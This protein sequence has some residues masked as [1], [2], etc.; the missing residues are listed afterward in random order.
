M[1]DL[2]TR[3]ET[4]A[5]GEAQ[6]ARTAAAEFVARYGRSP[7]IS[8]APGRV[9]LIGEH[10]DYNDG[11]VM[12]A[13]L[14][15]STLVA[16]SPR[17]E[18]LVRVYSES[19]G[20]ER[21][22]DLDAPDPSARRDWSDYVFGVAAMLEQSGRRLQGADLVVSSDVPIGAG[23]SSSA[24]LEVATAHALL[25]AA[26]LPFDPVEAAQI[27]QR[28]ENEFVGMRCGIM[29]QYIAARGVAGCALLIDCRTLEAR[30]VALAPNLRLLITDSRVRHQHAGGEY[31]ARRDACEE[32]VRRLQPFLG[33]I[34]ALRD[35]TFE[36][37]EAHKDALSDLVYRR[38]R[39]IVTENARVLEMERALAARDFAAAGRAMNASHA[40][41]RDDFEIT[42]PEVDF[43]ADF[44][45]GL[46]GVWGSRMTGGGFG[47]CTVTLVEEA[48]VEAAAG[49]IVQAYREAYQIDANT[50]VCAPSQGAHFV[51]V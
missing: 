42:C 26:G 45:Q 41:M 21:V 46:P 27:S 18:R 50:F 35:V 40:H 30:N 20:A 6:R 51:A 28:A 15:F 12:P 24:A 17:P 39:H 31:N 2:E 25:A 16:A 37:L 22:F 5:G 13:A 1:S 4:A 3:R 36:Q 47:G 38:C 19:E 34:T 14:E 11:Y 23:L 49:R 7:R 29:D 43:L 33:P 10:T 48:A 32:G 9:N 8:A 44:A